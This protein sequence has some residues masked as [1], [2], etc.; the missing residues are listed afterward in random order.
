[1]AM[2]DEPLLVLIFP[3]RFQVPEQLNVEVDGPNPPP[4]G[5]TSEN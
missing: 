3:F 2:L 4:I 1:M 5:A